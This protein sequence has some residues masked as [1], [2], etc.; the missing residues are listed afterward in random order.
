MRENENELLQEER[1][2]GKV[3]SDKR[4]V[5]QMGRQM[6]EWM[7]VVTDH[8]EKHLKN[9]DDKLTQHWEQFD[10]KLFR[11]DQ[12]AELQFHQESDRLESV[13]KKFEQAI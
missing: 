12:L 5:E 13:L 2:N 11:K 8:L 3:M 7:R 10:P 9:T 6:Q 1:E 4:S